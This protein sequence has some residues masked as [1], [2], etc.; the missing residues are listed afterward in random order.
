MEAM[1]L[2]VTETV[3][4]PPPS[5]ADY[6]VEAMLD[7]VQAVTDMHALVIGPFAIDVMCGLI[8][9]GCAAASEVPFEGRHPTQRAEIVLVPHVRTLSDA[10]SAI[11][12]ARRALLPCGRIAFR[13]VDTT[14]AAPISRM[15][16]D[17]GFSAMRTSAHPD[18]TIIA[19][20]LPMFGLH[21][22]T[23]HA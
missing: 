23:S 5:S 19:G 12:L 6:G 20:D 15:L 18:G 10:K 3:P 2:A 13:V 21:N 22:E 7:T 4:Q 8:R 9:R 1:F 16:R 11:L 17:A 14:L